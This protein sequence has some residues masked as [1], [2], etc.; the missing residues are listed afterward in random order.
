M[1]ILIE[2][3]FSSLRLNSCSDHRYFGPGV[4][5]SRSPR[6]HRASRR[7]VGHGAAPVP[8]LAPAGPLV[9]TAPRLAMAAVT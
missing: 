9:T 4:P 8:Q 5:R 2:A 7:Y 1:R 3:I 6:T